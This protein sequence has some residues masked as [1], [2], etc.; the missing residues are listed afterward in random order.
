MTNALNELLEQ[1][2][3][4]FA[5][6]AMGTNL[7]ELGLNNGACGE[8]WNVESPAKVQSIH[9]SF[10]DAGSDIILTNTFGA[11]RYRLALHA[12]AERV[13]ELN[14]AGAAIA[15]EI[16]DM[17]DRPVIVAGSVGP[18][19]D[20]LVP[21]GERTQAEAEEA[22]YEQICALAEGGADVAW[23]ETIF[24]ENEL[25]AAIKGA[26]RAGLPYVSTM[27][28]DTGGKTMMGITAE[29]AARHTCGQTPA[30]IAF[31]A[32]CGVGPAQMLD[33]IIGLKEGAPDDAVVVAKCNCGVPEMGSDMKIHYS[34]TPEIMA[35][36]ARL[37]RDA[38]VR[39]I[40]GCCGTTAEHIQVMV[41]AVRDTPRG[42]V[43]TIEEIRARLGDLT[44]T[45]NATT[46]EAVTAAPTKRRGR[47]KG[48][49]A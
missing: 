6:G 16:A 47:R 30:P 18:T 11:N 48:R 37:A 9:K 45:A 7:F 35:D 12:G 39:I 2:D 4:L 22:F 24:A 32:N 29:H 38:G 31:G 19:G 5:D 43:P 20:V 17:V 13:G 44:D 33:T 23:I 10:V 1:R 21:L 40:G 8:V 46:A 26:E 25:D 41:D 34:G 42:A 27:T 49:A 14:R 28:F 15:R 3:V 36:Y